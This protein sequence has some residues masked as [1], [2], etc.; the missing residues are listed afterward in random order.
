M[1]GPLSLQCVSL[2]R[3]MFT[4][5]PQNGE[6]TVGLKGERGGGTLYLG[7]AVHVPFPIPTPI[8]ALF[9][10]PPHSQ[11]LQFFI[12]VCFTVLREVGHLT[13]S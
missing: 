10:P 5:T 11:T 6:L 1:L 13:Q 12:L 9:L 8:T 4:K 7:E 2:K 3:R